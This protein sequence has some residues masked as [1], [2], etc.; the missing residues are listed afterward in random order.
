MA[1]RGIGYLPLALPSR[2]ATPGRFPGPRFNVSSPPAYAFDR[3]R[4][5]VAEEDS[6]T[7][8]LIIGTLRRDGHC[9]VHEPTALSGDHSFSLAECHL[10]ISSMRLE[11]VMRMDLL[12]ET[13]ERL[14]ALPILYLANISQSVAKLAAQLPEGLAVLHAPFTPAELQAAVLPLLPRLRTGT[15]LA[16]PASVPDSP[17][18]GAAS[19][20][21][22][23]R[24]PPGES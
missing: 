6:A 17:C 13:R 8:A 5:V 18:A 16:L 2:P 15:I 10:L 9:V 1:S 20:A 14:P 24:C 7:A 21:A 3:Q 23:S 12:E 11:G 22:Q 19:A 4:I